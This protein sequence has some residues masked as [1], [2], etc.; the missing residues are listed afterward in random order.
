LRRA[1]LA[2]LEAAGRQ[3]R[4]D[5]AHLHRL[6]LRLFPDHPAGARQGRAD[7]AAAELDHGIGAARRRADRSIGAAAV[8]R[9][10]ARVSAMARALA[11]PGGPELTTAQAAAIAAEYQV[12][13]EPDDQGEVKNRPGRLADVFPAPFP[14]E[15]AA[16]ARFNAVP[17][18]MSVIAKARGYERGFPWW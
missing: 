11:E 3:L 8:G 4:A 12:K 9:R 2:R 18:D 7:E 16:R 5:R 6:L 14:N 1:R 17:P 13:G 10:G 15:Q